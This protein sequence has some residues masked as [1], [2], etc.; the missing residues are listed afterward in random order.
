M[1]E[2]EKR[3]VISSLSRPSAQAVEEFDP[4]PAMRQSSARRV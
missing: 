3:S 4:Q 2:G 1:N